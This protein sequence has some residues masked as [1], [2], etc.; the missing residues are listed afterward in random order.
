MLFYTIRI[1]ID[2]VKL[3]NGFKKNKRYEKKNEITFM[4]VKRN[5]T[6]GLRK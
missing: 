4:Y 2:N 6:V 1:F 3:S 5:N